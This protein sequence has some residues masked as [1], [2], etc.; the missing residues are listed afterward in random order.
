M[1]VGIQ[2]ADIPRIRFATLFLQSMLAQ[3]IFVA[4]SLVYLAALPVV[5][6]M[7]PEMIQNQSAEMIVGIAGVSVPILFFSLVLYTFCNMVITD[8]PDRP[9]STLYHRVKKVLTSPLQM[10]AGLPL[11]ASLVLFFYPFT[12]FKGNVGVI[13]PYA[14]DATFDRWDVALH[15]GYRPWELLQ[16]LFGYMPV[17]FLLNFNY[18][19]WFFVLNF[20]WVHYTFMARPGPERTRFFLTFFMIWAIIGSLTAIAF[21]SAGP[22]YYGFLH[23]GEIN[24]YAALM[25]YLHGI[26]AVIPIWAVSTQDYL[27]AEHG[28]GSLLGGVSAMASIHNA[29]ALLF[30]LMTWKKMRWL[31]NLMIAHAVLIFLGSIHLGWHYAV[32]SYVAWV[33]ALGLWWL[34]GRITAWWEGRP[35]VQAFN[36]VHQGGA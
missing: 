15:F 21:S 8:R 30:V 19:L 22:C 36:H 26:N 12:V 7:F 6:W 1:G 10:A 24:S 16:P 13:Q 29:T 3:L 31:R 34:A 4:I 32:D 11:F 5:G 33:M 35:T 14:W 9:L 25:D 28:A 20:F 23:P 2:T 18:N 27:W 17:T